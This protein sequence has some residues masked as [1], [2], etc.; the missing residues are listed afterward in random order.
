MKVPFSFSLVFIVKRILLGISYN[1]LSGVARG[2]WEKFLSNNLITFK[3][4]ISFQMEPDT[5]LSKGLYHWGICSSGGSVLGRWNWM[6]QSHWLCISPSWRLQKTWRAGRWY[7]SCPSSVSW[8]LDISRPIFLSPSL[9]LPRLSFHQR[10]DKSQVRDKCLPVLIRNIFQGVSYPMDNISLVFCLGKCHSNRP[11]LMPASPSVQMT[12]ISFM[13]HFFN[14]FYAESQYFDLSFSPMLI[15][16]TSFLPPA[17]I[18]RIT[19]AASFRIPPPL[20]W[21]K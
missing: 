12:R 7:L 9:M 4:F 16:R 11:P 6:T 2:K 21:T 20:L 19:Y 8:N 10:P 14:L 3:H 15:I 5:A 1:I 13:P 17:L 18:L